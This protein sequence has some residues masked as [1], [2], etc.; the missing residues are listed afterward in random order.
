MNTRIWLLI[1]ALGLA[2][3]ATTA[4]PFG[5][6]PLV[7]QCTGFVPGVCTKCNDPNKDVSTQ[8]KNCLSGYVTNSVGKCVPKVS[9]NPTCPPYCECR[10]FVPW[11]CTNCPDPNA[12]LSTQCKKCNTGYNKAPPKGLCTKD[13]RTGTGSIRGGIT[14]QVD[15]T[16]VPDFALINSFVLSQHPELVGATVTKLS[17]QVV[18]GMNYYISYET[19]T[20]RYDVVVWY[21]AWLNNK[22]ITSFTSSPK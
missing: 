13:T 11:T 2:A 1:V 5:P 14:P 10:G 15:T 9:S 17:T 20:T 4:G 12:D 3:A 16:K 7:C 18:S 19:A 8:C 6:C 21:Q 22:Q